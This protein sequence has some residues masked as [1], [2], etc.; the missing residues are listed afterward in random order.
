MKIFAQNKTRRKF[1]KC[2]IYSQRSR[3]KMPQFVSAALRL[4]DFTVPFSVYALATILCLRNG[5]CFVLSKW[6]DGAKF[7]YKRKSQRHLWTGC[8]S[9]CHPELDSGSINAKKFQN[10]FILFAKFCNF[11]TIIKM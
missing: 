1:Y 3:R 2:R 10:F 9:S 8:T 4:Q 11:F 6:V 7:R 5:S